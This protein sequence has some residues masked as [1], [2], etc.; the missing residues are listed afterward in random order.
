[1]KKLTLSLI[2]IM[3]TYFLNSAEIKVLA[4]AGSTRSESYNKKLVKEAAERAC[5][6][7]AKITVIDLKDF[8]MPLYEADLEKEKGMPENA[9]KLRQIMMAHDAMIIA[10][11]E[12][13]ASIPA[14]LK[15]ALD[16]ASRSEEGEGSKAAFKGKKIAIMCATPGKR[17][18]AHALSHLRTVLQDVGGIV[19][20]SQLGIPRIYEMT[21]EKEEN[22]QVVLKQMLHELLAESPVPAVPK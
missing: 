8:P 14:L 3:S 19:V 2:T 17:G 12:Y 1:M 11:P 22:K 13:N 20:P 6:M 18:G 4:F 16:W 21:P 15:N 7:G 5:E 9:K 10:S